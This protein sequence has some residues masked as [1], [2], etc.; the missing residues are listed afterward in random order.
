MLGWLAKRLLM[1]P[2]MPEVARPDGSGSGFRP[3][4]RCKAAIMLR[5]LPSSLAEPASARNSRFR[6]NQATMTLARTPNTIWLTI[7]VMV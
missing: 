1:L 2:A 7:T 3:P 4:R 6:E 5:G